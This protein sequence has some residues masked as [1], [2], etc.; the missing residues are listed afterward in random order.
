KYNFIFHSI[1]T[2]NYTLSVF[3]NVPYYSSQSIPSIVIVGSLA[4]TKMTV[5]GT[6]TGGVIPFYL[7]SKV[8]T[9]V[10]E[11]PFLEAPPILPLLYFYVNTS[12][13]SPS[14]I[15]IALGAFIFVLLIAFVILFLRRV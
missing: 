7:I 3:S 14:L 13:A 6:V 2:G 4:Q 5:D 9:V 8:V 1:P 10:F 11:G 15:Y 12:G